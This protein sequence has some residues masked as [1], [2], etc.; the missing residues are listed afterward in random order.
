MRAFSS[1]TGLGAPERLL[2]LEVCGNSIFMPEVTKPR[3]QQ[4]NEGR[5]VEY[6]VRFACTHS[7]SR[8]RP[9][10]RA[11]F[12]QILK[13]LPWMSDEA[14]G[15]QRTA[16][17]VIAAAAKVALSPLHSIVWSAERSA[18]VEFAVAPEDAPAWAVRAAPAGG[19]RL[20]Q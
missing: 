11:L 10:S 2:G 9:H 7:L 5:F 1:V 6:K 20:K 13:A 16:T 14:I 3:A 12:C 17:S 4:G 8:P 18:R 19:E 15:Y